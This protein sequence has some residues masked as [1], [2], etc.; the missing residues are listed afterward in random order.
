M[1]SASHLG[2]LSLKNTGQL[3]G[4]EPLVPE[5]QLTPAPRN[6]SFQRDTKTSV[7]ALQV[8]PVIVS[9]TQLGSLFST[10]RT[11]WAPLSTEAG[12]Q[13]YPPPCIIKETHPLDKDLRAEGESASP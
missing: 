4:I 7:Q 2:N 3:Q 6:P 12:K 11:G 13:M 10:E 1:S 9:R 5:T 8:E